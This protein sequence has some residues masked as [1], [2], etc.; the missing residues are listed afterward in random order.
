MSDNHGGDETQLYSTASEVVDILHEV[1]DITQK[2]M[3][4]TFRNWVSVITAG[5]CEQPNRADEIIDKQVRHINSSDKK[6]DQVEQRFTEA[7]ELT[8]SHWKEHSQPVIGE[9][10]HIAGRNRD[11]LGQYFTPWPVAKMMASLST[12]SSPGENKDT[13]EPITIADNAGCGSGRTL[14]AAA[15]TIQERTEDHPVVCYG[16]DLDQTCAKMAVINLF[17]AQLSGV[18][19]NGNALDP[20]K[21]FKQ[22]NIGLAA[23]SGEMVACISDEDEISRP[24]IDQSNQQKEQAA[25]Q[26]K[27]STNNQKPNSPTADSAIAVD[28]GETGDTTL[29]DFL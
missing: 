4:K 9:A 12:G 5:L 18:I 1:G 3:G 24:Y 16:I 14:L 26:Q 23:P 13:S 28:T 17:T 10:Y 2:Q 6:R 8:L 27:E 19:I 7:F 25:N 21:S 22:W 15:T 11:A 20:T 29:T